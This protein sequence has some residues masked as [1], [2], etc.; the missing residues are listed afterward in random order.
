MAVL[1]EITVMQALT[2][3]AFAVTLITSIWALSERIQKKFSATVDKKVTEIVNANNKVQ[4]DKLRATM[5]RLD[6]RQA[7]R[8]NSLNEKIDNF[9]VTQQD[10]NKSQDAVLERQSRAIIESYKQNIRNI[11]YHLRD[12]GEIANEDKAYLDKIYPYYIALGGNSD[13][14]AKY[15]E[16]CR[17]YERRTQEAYDR[18]REKQQQKKKRNSTEDKDAVDKE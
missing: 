4:D 3:V 9:I 14:R 7:N 11:Y 5:D 2:F 8:I 10:Y 12:T 17:V 13:I 18:A 15:E 16:I 1:T 6:E